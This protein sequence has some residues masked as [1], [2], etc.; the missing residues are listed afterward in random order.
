MRVDHD[1]ISRK[2]QLTKSKKKMFARGA[3]FHGIYI[4]E[5]VQLGKK[6]KSWIEK[7]L[8]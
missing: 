2:I 6:V 1:C 7:K 8:Q 3:F 5:Y 4:P